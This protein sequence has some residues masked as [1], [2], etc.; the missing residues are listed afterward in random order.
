[1]YIAGGNIPVDTGDTYF[2]EIAQ[3]PIAGSVEAKHKLHRDEF[4]NHEIAE[5]KPLN[6]RIEYAAWIVDCPNCGNAEYAF[7]DK[8]FL[9]SLCKNSNVGGRIYKVKMPQR[10][11]KIEELLAKRPIKNRHWFPTESVQDLENENISHGLEVE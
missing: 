4:K 1:M 7:E 10:R 9:C 2:N 11:K 8:L 5:G 3:L 6:A